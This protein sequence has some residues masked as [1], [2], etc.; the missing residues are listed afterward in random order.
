MKISPRPIACLILFAA[1]VTLSGNLAAAG[2]ELPQPSLLDEIAR[3]YAVVCQDGGLTGGRDDLVAHAEGRVASRAEAWEICQNEML[4][5]FVDFPSAEP[6]ATVPL[7]V[8]AGTVLQVALQDEVKVKKEGQPVSGFL[9]EPLYAFDQEVIPVGSEVR[10]RIVEIERVSRKTRLFA[11]LSFNFSPPRKVH[12][13]FDEIILPDGFRI[14]METETVLGS[15]RPLQ[16]VTAHDARQKRAAKDTAV[17]MMKEQVQEAKRKWNEAVSQVKTPGRRRRLERYAMEQL[18]V[19][20][21][22]LNP[23][24]VYFAELLEPLG[25]GD[26]PFVPPPVA[27][28]GAP[29]PS[30]TLLAHAQLLTPLDSAATTKDTPVEAIV[31]RP[32]FAGDRLLFPQGSLLKGSVVTVRP[33]RSF[34]RNGE[35]R[36]GFT[37]L[38]LPGELPQEVTTSIEGVQGGTEENVRLDLEGG[39]RSSNS[40]KRYMFTGIAVG[41]AIASHQDSDVEDGVGS[42][43]GGVR[44]GVAGGLNALKLVGAV[45]GGVVRSQT[46]S[47]WMG[48]FGMGRSVYDN[49][50]SRG[51]EVTFPKGTAMEVGFWLTENC[52]DSPQPVEP[53]KGK[54]PENPPQGEI[55]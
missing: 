40:K 24:T 21:Q 55:R 41:L 48:M 29:L 18:P 34:K 19:R 1:A 4:A 53:E 8:P 33:A 9:V 38:T 43:Q 15:G 54:T 37:E 42:T 32:L 36:I 25:F 10:G 51:R 5:A 23:G 30:C 47:F 7:T 31:T 27:A 12:V 22:Y 16:L 3:T 39:A 35:L 44:E 52:N 46:F 14:P 28:D 11:A 2:P 6:T 45:A 20:P 49:F 50:I 17:Q 13:E 26:K